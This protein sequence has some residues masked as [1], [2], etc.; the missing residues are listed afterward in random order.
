MSSTQELLAS[1]QI[2][3]EQAQVCILALY[4]VNHLPSVFTQ[5]NFLSTESSTIDRECRGAVYFA[6]GHNQILGILDM[7]QQI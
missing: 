1:Y 7:S 2:Y 4:V 3:Q 6:T 5:L